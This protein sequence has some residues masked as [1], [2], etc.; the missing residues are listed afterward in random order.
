M[1]G[2]QRVEM[3]DA[4]GVSDSRDPEI[5]P[6]RST[7]GQLLTV[8]EAIDDDDNRKSRRRGRG[9]RAKISNPASFSKND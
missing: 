9:R 8:D 5:N 2:E 6:T 3:G 7:G 1:G 4:Q